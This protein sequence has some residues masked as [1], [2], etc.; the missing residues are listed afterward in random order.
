MAHSLSAIKRHRQSLP[1]RARNQAR[2]SAVRSAVRR[3]RELIEAGA[4]EEAESAVRAAGSILDRAAQKGTLHRNN[5]ARR[6]SR[7]VRQLN[8]SRDGETPKR[9]APKKRAT[10]AKTS[11]RKTT[12]RSTTRAKKS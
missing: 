10:R 8:A 11:G 4:P 2:R 7:L 12:A 1:R 3:A 9:A 6:K 5:A